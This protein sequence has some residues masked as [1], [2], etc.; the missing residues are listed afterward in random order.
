MHSFQYAIKEIVGILTGD[1]RVAHTS[2][3]GGVK[4]VMSQCTYEP[5]SL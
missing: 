3:K 1:G 2:Q 5:G 4:V